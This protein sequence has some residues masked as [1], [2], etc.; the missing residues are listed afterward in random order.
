MT[1]SGR[2]RIGVLGHVDHGK[3][4]LT[5]AITRVLRE[6]YPD[7]NRL[8]GDNDWVVRGVEYQTRDRRYLHIDPSPWRDRRA[9]LLH[10]APLDGAILV[11]SAVEGVMAQTRQDVLG[12][13][14]LGVP[15]LVVALNKADQ[16][17]DDLAAAVE[18]EVRD[19]L[20]RQGYHGTEVPV[21]RVSA[22]HALYGDSQWR[23]SILEL[24]EAVDACVPGPG[25]GPVHDAETR[26]RTRFD[27]EVYLATSPEG[28]S[29]RPL[30]PG[31][32]CRFWFRTAEVAGTVAVEGPER[33][34]RRSGGVEMLLPGDTAQVRV[35][36]DEPVAL[37]DQECFVVTQ[38]GR[39]GYAWGRVTHALG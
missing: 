20:T 30:W 15:T 38:P 3:T 33:G 14:W 37:G 10:A 7:R 6:E 16:V 13:R 36:L 18:A 24:M 2:V 26:H 19:E 25:S 17:D 5:A 28:G 1:G 22:F 8:A 35:T 11:V 12:A 39:S 31:S 23:A 4:T 21:V 29:P 34:P 9:S 27:A 32:V